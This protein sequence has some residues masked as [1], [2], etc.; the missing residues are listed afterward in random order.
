MRE[1]AFWRSNG[2]F[3]R[4]LTPA[5]A[6]YG[7]V[8]DMRMYREGRHATVPVLCV[9]SATVGGAGKT[10]TAIAVAQILK[11]AGRVPF[12][13]SRGYGGMAAKP[14]LVDP[15]VHGADDVGDEPL[16]LARFVPTMVSRDR[17][18]GA[19]AACSLGADVVVMD[20]GFQNPGLHKNRS[21]LAVDGRRGIGNRLVFPAGPLRAPLESQLRRANAVLIIGAGA[22]GQAIADAAHARDLAVFHGRL[23]P[24]A[25][26][27]AGLKG[28][29]LLA[30]AGIGDPDKFFATLGAAG[31]DVRAHVPFP[32][33]HRYR[34]AEASDL[35][36]RAERQ[37]LVLVTTEKDMARLAKQDD[38]AALAGVARPFP[39]RLVVDEAGAFRDFV[40]GARR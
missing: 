16:L 7:A 1:P 37:R 15:A 13:L 22:P 33:H 38:L 9:G 40:L 3:A 20:D 6:V 2:L 24:D 36:A 25:D 28:R 34:R 12:V 17:V 32:D 4:L 31:L 18:A 39:V 23:E 27:L 5:A 21:I 14:T 30:F 11:A 10:P 19:M 29:P 8:A 35:I 26:A